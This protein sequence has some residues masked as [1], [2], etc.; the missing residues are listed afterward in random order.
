MRSELLLLFLLSLPCIIQAQFGI[1]GSYAV[2]N[3]W[4]IAPKEYN[5]TGNNDKTGWHF[6]DD[7]WTTGIDYRIK[8]KSVRIKFVPELNYSRLT[9]FAASRD[10]NFK[11][12]TSVFSFYFN[13][14]LYLFDLRGNDYALN[15]KKTASFLKRGLF[16]R[17]SPG[18]SHWRMYDSFLDNIFIDSKIWGLNIAGSLGLDIEITDLLTITPI[19]GVRTHQKMR[20]LLHN[21]SSNSS[22]PE[23]IPLYA[24]PVFWNAGL[25]VGVQ[26][27]HL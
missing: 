14:D 15:N 23:P 20:V 27:D 25:R 6:I 5:N 12:T 1:T 4:W 13:T 8:F 7:G 18:I 19:I 9:R 24:S 17:L 10:K 16:I 11:N 3:D 2:T 26:L 21:I 22:S